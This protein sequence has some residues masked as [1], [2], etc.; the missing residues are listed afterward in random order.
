M[1]ARGI[2]WVTPSSNNVSASEGAALLK[3]LSGDKAP[4]EVQS[5]S[6]G[7]WT[8]RS[9]A[10][11]KS[12]L[13]GGVLPS[14]KLLSKVLACLRIRHVECREENSTSDPVSFNPYAEMSLDDILSDSHPHKTKVQPEAIF[15]KRAIQV[16]PAF[17]EE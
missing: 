6:L 8:D 12:A 4:P 10:I 15:D 3:A 16:R 17:C 14:L 13:S 7:V 9:I 1:V 5:V 11:Y 2:T